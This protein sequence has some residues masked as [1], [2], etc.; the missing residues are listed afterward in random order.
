MNHLPIIEE[1]RIQQSYPGLLNS[2]NRIAP[3][4]MEEAAA[5][6]VSYMHQHGFD[7][8]RAIDEI[9]PV[10]FNFLWSK[11][12]MIYHFND[13]LVSAFAEQV[14]RIDESE[15]IPCEFL[16]RLPYPCIAVE[17]TPFSVSAVDRNTNN[18]A[19]K[20]DFTG[21]F[22]LIYEKKNIMYDVPILH[23]LFEMADGD[24]SDYHMPVVPSGTIK[25]SI[26]ALHE[27][28]LSENE[29]ISI[30]DAK[31]EMTAPLLAMQVVLYLQSENA[32]IKKPP[33]KS[34]RRKKIPQKK[35]AASNPSTPE[36]V[37]VGYRVGRILRE[38]E[39]SETKPSGTGSK[40]RPHSRR[41]H[42]HHYWTGPKNNP[43]HRK[44]VIKWISPMIIHGETKQK[45]TTVVEIDPERKTK[46][47]TERF[48]K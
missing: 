42:W 17:I 32:D 21:R 1:K 37:R 35:N 23:G 26:S 10:Y 48:E 13:A 5:S 9:S 15:T 7:R 6:I 39:T 11:H 2:L 14:K 36:I 38:Y 40:K 43:E 30:D 27:F 46:N 31:A 12:R 20:I 29:T 34:K 28:I 45:T 22:Y 24:L 41:G 47:E 44:R 8:E 25:D 18:Q 3:A 4:T 33:K 19:Y 16:S